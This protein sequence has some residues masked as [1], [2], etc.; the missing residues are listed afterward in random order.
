MLL[1]RIIPAAAVAL[2]VI[3]C[4]LFPY[5]RHGGLSRRGLTFGIR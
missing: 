5:E 3:G 2:V 4:L 1:H